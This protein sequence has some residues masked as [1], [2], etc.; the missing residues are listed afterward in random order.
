[1]LS[2]DLRR[3]F[4]QPAF[5]LHARPLFQPVFFVDIALILMPPPPVLQIFFLSFFQLLIE[6]PSSTFA[7][8]FAAH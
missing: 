5:L 8:R 3:Y 1:M 6:S 4:R 2:I 7:L